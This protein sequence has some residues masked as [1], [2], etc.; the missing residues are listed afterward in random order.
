MNRV[1]EYLV[2]FALF[3]LFSVVGG[4]YGFIVMAIFY[5]YAY[6]YTDLSIDDIPYRGIMDRPKSSAEIDAETTDL[7]YSPLELGEFN[8]VPHDCRDTY[9]EYLKSPEWRILRTSALKRDLHRC[10]RCGYIGDRLQVHHTSYQ[11]IY[12]LDF[13]LDQLETVCDLCHS[14]IHTGILPMAKD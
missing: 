11:G 1:V 3:V 6:N 4:I 13:H 7:T 9:R 14:D 12:T 2:V 10:V 8:H 5:M